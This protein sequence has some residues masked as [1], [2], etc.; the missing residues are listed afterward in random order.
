VVHLLRGYCS[1]HPKLWDEQL[2][3]VQHAYN[4]AMHSSTQR[5][6]FEVCLGYFPK[7]PMEFSFREENKED[8]KNDTD[9]A[10]RF[11]QRIQQV[12]QEVHEQLEKIQA[13]Y[14]VRHDKH[15]VDHQFQVGDQVWLHINKDRM[16]G[17]GKN[18]KP[19]WYGP[20]K[21]LEKIGTNAFHLDLP[22]YMKCIQW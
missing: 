7:S 12:H 16:K 22:S 9:K 21:I 5:T 17:E 3:Y 6:P 13:K 2:H 10:K 8:E 20:F 4:R 1:K 15:R 11:I 19:I 18:L 14:K